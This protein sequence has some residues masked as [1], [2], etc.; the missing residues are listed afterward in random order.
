MKIYRHD[1]STRL[2]QNKKEIT[3]YYLKDTSLSFIFFD[4]V[5]RLFHSQLL[6]HI[7]HNIDKVEDKLRLDMVFN[8]VR[9]DIVFYVNFAVFQQNKLNY[10]YKDM[11]RSS[12]LI[13]PFS[14]SKFCFAGQ[15]LKPRKWSNCARWEYSN[16]NERKQSSKW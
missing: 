14:Y 5:S 3:I 7:I 2:N 11:A 12:A 6:L 16:Y 15:Q 1:I 9:N 10:A 8:L 4:D 13:T